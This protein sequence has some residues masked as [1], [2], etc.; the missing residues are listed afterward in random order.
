MAKNKNKPNPEAE[1][2]GVPTPEEKTP[3]NGANGNPKKEKPEGK[4]CPK[5]SASMRDKKKGN[6]NDP[7]W[8]IDADTTLASQIYNFS[9]T[10]FVGQP[11]T[12]GFTETIPG[13]MV[14]AMNPAAGYAPVNTPAGMS[15]INQVGL[16]TFTWLSGN[17]AKTTMY[18]PQDVTIAT[19]AIGQVLA[20]AGFLRRAIGLCY[21]Y[22]VRNRL[23][24]KRLIEALGIDADDLFAHLAQY[25][26]RYNLLSVTA[27]KI[28]FPR[29]VNYFK[30]CEAVYTH[31]F[32]DSTNPMSQMY[33]YTPRTTWSLDEKSDTKGSRLRTRIVTSYNTVTGAVTREKLS[34]YFDIVD[35][36]LNA[37]LE[38]GTLN[39]VYSDVIRVASQKGTELWSIPTIA[40]NYSVLPEFSREAL[41]NIHNCWIMGDPY[42]SVNDV[43]KVNQND[44]VA[45]ADTNAIEYHPLFRR[46]FSG[47]ADFSSSLHL[48]NFIDPNPGI[49]DRIMA[50]RYSADFNDLSVLAGQEV[51]TGYTWNYWAPRS[52]GD[53]YVAR[54]FVVKA[55]DDDNEA[56]N[57]TSVE[58]VKDSSLL[59]TKSAVAAIPA[60]PIT[61]PVWAVFDWAPILYQGVVESD[62]ENQAVLKL[63]HTFADLGYY[64]SVDDNTLRAMKDLSV[65]SLFEFKQSKSTK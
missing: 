10:E 35:S 58:V 42:D 40:D 57:N 27:S 31:L 20:M 8:L 17:N 32:Q 59:I 46:P 23:V 61:A 14:I 34:H 36:M 54:V 15:P 62:V 6:F 64:T 16:R 18:G 47:G 22:N 12:H 60:E 38:S 52:M 39:Y 56:A 21:T 65:Y 43:F 55:R 1:K 49:E 7:S 51:K 45:N 5:Y 25:R 53:Y 11:V 19:L 33:V 9:F 41:Y 4:E 3:K 26:V 30:M 24:P 2:P 50:T 44:V 48:Y 28:P 37:L 63:Q 13:I 29:M